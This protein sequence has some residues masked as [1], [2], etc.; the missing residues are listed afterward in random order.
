MYGEAQY[1]LYHSLATPFA[2]DF[3]QR[4]RN[5][6]GRGVGCKKVGLCF[7]VGTYGKIKLLDNKFGQRGFD[8]RQKHVLTQFF[9]FG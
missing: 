6:V 2:T 7:L 3:R 4:G 8:G 5:G 9:V 1:Y